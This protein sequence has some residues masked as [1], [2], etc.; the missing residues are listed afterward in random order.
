VPGFIIAI[1]TSIKNIWG[2]FMIDKIIRATT[3]SAVYCLSGI[4]QCVDTVQH[5]ADVI[6]HPL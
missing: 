4:P 3:H 2:N 1:S 6:N 5:N